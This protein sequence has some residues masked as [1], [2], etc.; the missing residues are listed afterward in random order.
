MELPVRGWMRETHRKF[1]CGKNDRRYGIIVNTPSSPTD[2]KRKSYITQPPTGNPL[3]ISDAPPSTLQL[4]QL[5]SPLLHLSRC[6]AL[7][8]CLPTSLK[9]VCCGSLLKTPKPRSL[10]N[11][12]DQGCPRLSFRAERCPAR[13]YHPIDVS[14]ASLEQCWRLR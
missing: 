11:S 7:A 10:R 6:C 3:T 1:S 13:R 14:T 2:Q 12:V 8:P 4:T 9:L 5:V